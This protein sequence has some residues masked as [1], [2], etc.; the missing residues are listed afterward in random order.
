MADVLVV[1]EASM[2][3]LPQML[4]LVRLGSI[5]IGEGLHLIDVSEKRLNA[6]HR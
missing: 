5:R 1:D 6:K 3:S 4:W 2:L